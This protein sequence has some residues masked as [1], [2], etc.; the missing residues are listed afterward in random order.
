[1]LPAP[2]TFTAVNVTP[3]YFSPVKATHLRNLRPLP[4]ILQQLDLNRRRWPL[5]H[6]RRSILPACATNAPL[7]DLKTG[8]GMDGFFEIE[9]KVRDYEL[10]QF[11]VVNNAIYAS[12]CEHARH[13]LLETIGLSANAVARSGDAL[14]LS[15]FSIKF[16]APLRSGDKF[17]VKA[18]VSDTSAVRLF[19]EHFIYKLPNQEP[20]IEAKGTAVWLDKNYRPVRIPPEAK[21][22]LTQFL[23]NGTSS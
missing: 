13:E 3:T 11:G 12:Y 2:T 1:M 9:L 10:D 5:F 20:I 14:A 8:K 21:F 4:S 18:R 17:V 16:L 23:R 22:K 7:F 19:F 6:N 15:E